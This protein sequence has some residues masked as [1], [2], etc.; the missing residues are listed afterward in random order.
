MGGPVFHHF[1][2]I[3]VLLIGWTEPRSFPASTRQSGDLH[4]D[5]KNQHYYKLTSSKNKGEQ[6][7][8]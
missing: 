2:S 6:K 7:M 8:K 4:E 1:A 5:T 3:A